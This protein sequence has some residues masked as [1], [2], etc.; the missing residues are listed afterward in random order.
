MKRAGWIVL[1]WGEFAG[2]HQLSCVKKHKIF[3]IC[4]QLGSTKGEFQPIKLEEEVLLL[5]GLEN[6]TEQSLFLRSLDLGLWVDL[7][8]LLLMELLFTC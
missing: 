5:C 7:L 2:G 1:Y 8:L 4:G 6:E 3:L